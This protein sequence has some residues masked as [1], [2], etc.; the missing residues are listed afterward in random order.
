MRPR[1]GAMKGIRFAKVIG[2]GNDFILVDARRRPLP[3]S[4]ARLARGWCERRRGIGADG[5]LV[6]S[7]SR[8][9][10]ARMRIYNPDGSEA[11][12][13]GNGLRCAAW[14][15]HSQDHGR[16]RLRVETGA[17][18]LEA[19]VVGPERVRVFTG[20][21]RR[22]R[23]GLSLRHQGRRLFLHAVHSGVPH[24]VLFT[25]R[26]EAVDPSVTGPVIRHHRLFGSEG[27]NVDWVK[28]H[29][30]HELSIRTYERG[31][32]QETLA[33][34]TGAVAAVVI[35]AALGRLTP[36]VRVRTRGG[37]TLNVGFR[38]LRRGSSPWQE[39][40]LEGPARILFEGG[41]R[42]GSI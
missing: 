31:V 11:S 37:E 26:L 24:A 16:R 42:R 20:T 6:L 21:P 36:P 39:L 38:R 3:G 5:L 22:L 12:M 40:Y 30:P 41:L 28:V 9:A 10:D 1:T 7:S 2:S 33:C 15:L 14:Y 17:G 8:K 34:G 29:S 35:G 13:C 27:T 25:S 19:R 4:A 32:E 23:L 18:V